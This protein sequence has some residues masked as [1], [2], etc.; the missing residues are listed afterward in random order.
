VEHPIENLIKKYKMGGALPVKYSEYFGAKRR[1]SLM[2]ENIR[3]DT[4]HCL[5][6]S[7]PGLIAG[8]DLTT[9]IKLLVS[10]QQNFFICH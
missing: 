4:S 8:D 2:N 6:F 7:F 3:Y 10:I 1:K 9:L 5:L